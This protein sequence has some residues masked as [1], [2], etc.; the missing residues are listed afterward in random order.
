[1]SILNALLA[2]LR[3]GV[4]RD[5]GAISVIASLALVPIVAV[6]AV[7]VDGGRVWVDRQKVQTAAEAAA[8]S[9]G[10][11]W[12]RTGTACSTDATALVA[13]NADGSTTS[14]CSTTGTRYDGV[15]TVTATKVVSA[16]FGT[17][18]GRSG[19]TVT[20]TASVRV[21]AV[22]STSGLRPTAICNQ[23]PA[24]REWERSG[25]SASKTYTIGIEQDDDDDGYTGVCGRVPGNWGVID[26]DG[27]SNRT[28]D[29]QRWIDSGYDHSV[30]IDEHFA[31]DPGV[32]S[33]ALHM[34]GIIGKTVV[35][36]VYDRVTGTGAG[37]DY[38]I[39]GFVGMSVISAKLSGSAS[40]RNLVVKF[41]PV[42]LIGSGCGRGAPNYGTVTWQ[43]CSL[44]GRGVCS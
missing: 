35:I 22:S 27:G 26:F 9:A 8:M 19:T 33:P 30:S 18:I 6:T 20:S 14:T 21:G 42:Q 43:P 2:A 13:A 24:L 36:P 23:N 37:A 16:M 29:T 39:S 44:D 38:H 4:G 5:R 34:D 15:V 25:F 41:Q 11:L 32:P 7:M 28:P 12:A 17:I 31:G 3:P 1:M 40:Q 10:E